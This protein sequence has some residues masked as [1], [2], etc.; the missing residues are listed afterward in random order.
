M[1]IESSTG[2][3]YAPKVDR[4]VLRYM[5]ERVSDMKHSSRCLATEIKE[6]LHELQDVHGFADND[7]IHYMVNQ[8]VLSAFPVD[9]VDTEEYKD[10][11]KQALRCKD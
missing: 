7:W 4:E 10:R 6:A 1:T 9:Q 11:F 2:K 5:V 8:Y 3:K